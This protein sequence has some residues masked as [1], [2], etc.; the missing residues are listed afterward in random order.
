VQQSEL[1]FLQLVVA[2]VADRIA[3]VAVE[4]VDFLKAVGRIRRAL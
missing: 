3:V 2:A 4:P 1:I